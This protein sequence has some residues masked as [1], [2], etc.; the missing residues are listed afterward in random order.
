MGEEAFL[1]AIK[2]AFFAYS[3]S[4]PRSNAKLKVLHGFIANDIKLLLENCNP[5]LNFEV[6]SLNSNDDGTE[7]QVEGRYYPKKIDIVIKINN[8]I[9]AGI[10]LK[11]IMSNYYQNANNYFENMLGETANIRSINLKYFQIHII[12]YE[13]PYFDNK[14]KIKRWEKLDCNRLKKYLRLS[15]DDSEKYFH[16]PDKTLLYII[17]YPEELKEVTSKEEYVKKADQMNREGIFNIKLLTSLDN[18]CLEKFGKTV[19]VNDY[20][21]FIRKLVYSIL[22]V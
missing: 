11:F 12:P 14:N 7:E 16:T 22:S 19:I 21:G 8:E 17:E 13:L 2:D 5:K 4:G 1:N 15:E 10:G 18:G 3:N 6:I 20:E 9:I